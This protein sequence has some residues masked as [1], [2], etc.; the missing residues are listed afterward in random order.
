MPFT[1]LEKLY[2]MEIGVV[3]L[4]RKQLFGDKASML[5]IDYGL[6]Y[7]DTVSYAMSQGYYMLHRSSSTA[8]LAKSLPQE[9]NMSTNDTKSC[10]NY[11][12]TMAC[13]RLKE[14]VSTAD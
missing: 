2:E 6:L 1:F 10:N 8:P 11:G 12:Q 13:A 3:R 14:K 9:I 7:N 4:M 5:Y